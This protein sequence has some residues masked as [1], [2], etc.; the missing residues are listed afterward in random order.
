[1]FLLQPLPT[2][3]TDKRAIG[4]CHRDGAAPADLRPGVIEVNNLRRLGRVIPGS[5]VQPFYQQ[6]SHG[7]LLQRHCYN[8][9]SAHCL[10]CTVLL[11]VRT[12]AAFRRERTIEVKSIDMAYT[13]GHKFVDDGV[14]IDL[15]ALFLNIFD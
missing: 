14:S 3:R 12:L 10:P 1:M 11:F 9:I 5:S 6:A 8:V 2:E 15:L 13:V 4:E 7:Y